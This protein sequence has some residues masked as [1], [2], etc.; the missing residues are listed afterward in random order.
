VR[1]SLRIINLQRSHLLLL[2]LLLQQ[3]TNF[4]PLTIRAGRQADHHVRQRR[5]EED[6][7]LLSDHPTSI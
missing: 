7:A 5:T 2:L 1:V 3:G 4:Q 6:K